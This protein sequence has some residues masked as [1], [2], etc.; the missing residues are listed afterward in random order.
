MPAALSATAPVALAVCDCTKT[1]HEHGTRSMHGYHKCGCTPCREANRDYYR[2]A[3]RYKSRRPMVDAEL[4]RARV[5]V[6][7][8]A[9]MAMGDI[10]GLVGI[11]PSM[12]DY[13]VYGRK[14]RKPTKVLASTLDALNAISYRDAES[15]RPPAG[16]KLDGMTSRMQIQALYS[17]GWCAGSIETLTGVRASIITNLLRGS[18]V[19]EASRS[20]IEAV[21]KELRSSLPPEDDDRQRAAASR[22]R[23]RASNN[24]WTRGMAEDMEYAY[25]A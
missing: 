10:A 7:R 5:Q 8:S 4:V 12:L 25:A 24:G 23:H 11:R 1:T 2:R 6:L 20:A 18:G 21:Y 15:V 3:N 14:G 22:A 17:A 19:S 16:R 13:A 9:G